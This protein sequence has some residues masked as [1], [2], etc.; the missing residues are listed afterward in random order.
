MFWPLDR[1]VCQTGAALFAPCKAGGKARR[2]RSACCHELLQMFAIK[3]A[4]VA[5]R[6]RLHL[7]VC[8][9][10]WT[11][12]S[13]AHRAGGLR[14]GE[15]AAPGGR[16]KVSRVVAP[17]FS[18]LEFYSPQASIRTST[19]RRERGFWPMFWPASRGFWPE[20]GSNAPWGAL[21]CLRAPPTGVGAWMSAYAMLR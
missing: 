21:L 2:K 10:R 15:S 9:A 13:R 18:Q 20:L 17:V 14:C 6:F 19:S 1:I 7:G 11:E 16:E 8:A 12:R 4:A 5:Q 3:A